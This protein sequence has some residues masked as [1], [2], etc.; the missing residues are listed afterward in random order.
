M[1]M[2]ARR[3]LSLELLKMNSGK[4]FVLSDVKGNTS[5]PLNRG[6]IADLTL[7]RTLLFDKVRRT[8]FLRNNR[9]FCFVFQ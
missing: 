4:N 8:Y 2:Q 7:L 1:G 5:E 6:G 3:Y 9:L